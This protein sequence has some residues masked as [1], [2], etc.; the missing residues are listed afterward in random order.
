MMFDY[1]R[2]MRLALEDTARRIGQK[3]AAG[4]VAAIGAG[5]L[6]AA[7]W[8]WLA[9]HLDW[10]SAVAS[11]VLGA[12]F[13]ILGLGVMLGSGRVRH[14][15]PTPQDLRNEFEEKLGIATDVVIGRVSD[16]VG[17]T[18]DRAQ[19]KASQFVNEAENRLHSFADTVSYRADR[20]AETTEHKVQDLAARVGET[21]AKVGLTSENARKVGEQVSE[22]V[23]QAKASNLAAVAP[24]I[25]A[26]A[27][28]MTL[29]T[30]LQGWRHRD[31]D[32]IDEEDDFDDEY[33]EDFALDDF[34]DHAYAY[35]DDDLPRPSRGYRSRRDP[36]WV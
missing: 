30:R 10:G 21:A 12:V 33:D 5:F 29:A 1:A 19:A 7:L 15:P 4:V 17:Q 14:R 28:G 13:V 8:T 2:R 27:V 6:L 23:E 32:L 3:A 34:D 31:D 11:L 36:D 22:K 16:R 35:E 26:F 18:V 24:V 9:H 25:G 20:F